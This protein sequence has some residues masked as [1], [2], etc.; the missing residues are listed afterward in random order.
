M[1]AGIYKI[2]TNWFKERER[3][4]LFQKE[5]V[6]I[7]DEWI[8]DQFTIKTKCGKYELWINSGEKFFRDYSTTS[9]RFLT[10]FTTKEKALLWKEFINKG[11]SKNRKVLSKE[12]NLTFKINDTKT[13]QTNQKINNI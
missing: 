5:I 10:S 7:F 11:T 2:M 9:H 12:F 3:L 8:M 13:I 6:G 1:T 4:A